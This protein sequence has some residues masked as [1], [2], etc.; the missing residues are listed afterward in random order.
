MLQ[1]TWCS[2]C[3]QQEADHRARKR[4]FIFIL[5]VQ[6]HPMAFASILSKHDACRDSFP[7]IS[8]TT[9]PE[10]PAPRQRHIVAVVCPR[11]ER[12]A[13]N[14][15]DDCFRLGLSLRMIHTDSEEF[16]RAAIDALYASGEIG[17]LTHLILVGHGVNRNGQHRI[18]TQCRGSDE[19]DYLYPVESDTLKLLGLLRERPETDPATGKRMRW[20]G[21]IH[22]LSCAAEILGKQVAASAR[23]QAEGPNLFYGDLDSHGSSESSHAIRSICE[24]VH[25]Q[26]TEKPLSSASI[27]AWV[28]RTAAVPVTLAGG[29]VGSPIVVLPAQSVVEAMPA[30]L[31]GRLRQVQ[32]EEAYDAARTAVAQAD[33]RRVSEAMLQEDGRPDSLV[34][35]QNL[36]RIVHEQV[37]QDRLDQAAGLFA[38]APPLV[39]TINAFGQPLDALVAPARLHRYKKLA[40]RASNNCHRSAKLSKAAQASSEKD[41]KARAGGLFG[42]LIASSHDKVA[43]MPKGAGTTAATHG[44]MVDVGGASAYPQDGGLP[45]PFSDRRTRA[46]QD[47]EDTLLG[48]AIRRIA[49][50]PGYAAVLLERACRQGD[51]EMF[52]A[53]YQASGLAL[54]SQRVLIQSCSNQAMPPLHLACLIQAPEL[55]ATLL[56]H[57]A[58]VNQPDRTGK[59]ALH[60]AV[61][62]RSLALVKVLAGANADSTIQSEGMTPVVLA[63]RTGFDA[64][65]AALANAG[66]WQTL[67]AGGMPVSG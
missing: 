12:M 63:A 22:V 8:I 64:G 53:L 25:H 14:L 15:A 49:R 42:R 54:F 48:A 23:V 37:V 28:A 51:V 9:P 52:A 21:M 43:T 35:Q 45:E 27:L 4:F 3:R 5:F 67:S 65:F 44:R 40:R 58:D 11:E 13:R 16:T 7:I 31:P 34:L 30:F 50:E 41:G 55:V 32:V 26:G 10:P 19:N 62:A 57:G 29:D 39:H 33:M 47:T 24:V 46:R 56:E 1:R 66:F 38:D 20:K 2:C 17:D 36:A 61:E 60:H 59:T 6:A 18:E